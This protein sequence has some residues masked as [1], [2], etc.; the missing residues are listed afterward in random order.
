MTNQTNTTM[1][2]CT[3]T[4]GK[5][6]QTRKF[7]TFHPGGANQKAKKWLAKMDERKAA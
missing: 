2:T 3:A 4:H 6:Y 5:T 1:F 7:I